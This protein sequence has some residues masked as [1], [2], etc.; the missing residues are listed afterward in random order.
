MLYLF[1]GKNQVLSR[2]ALTT[3]RGEY[4]PSALT[5]FS[6]F[7]F[8]EFVEAC[9]ARSLFSPQRL[10]VLEVPDQ[11][12]LPKD[13]RFLEYLRTIPEKTSVAFW[14]GG[15][16]RKNHA[17]F[18][19]VRDA[20][21][22]Q[23]FP[24]SEEKPFPFLDALADKDL[25]GTYRELGKLSAKGRAELYLLQ[26]IAWKVRGLLQVKTGCGE[27]LNPFVYRRAASQSKNFSEEELV[28]IFDQLVEADVAM[29]TGSD[30]KL[31]L[32]GLLY[33]VCGLGDPL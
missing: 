9:E 2:Q 11:R 17:L 5:T 6:E 23:H 20:G 4:E 16:L 21:E 19:L 25:V 12:R 14:V 33:F 15:N 26:M 22:V 7:S 29:K 24:A 28:G 8:P 27:K 30:P 3:F 32:D 31:V 13:K 1:H 18:K 10:V